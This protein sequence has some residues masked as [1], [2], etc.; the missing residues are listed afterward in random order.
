MREASIS[1]NESASA[2]TIKTRKVQIII[3]QSNH[4][5]YASIEVNVMPSSAPV[6]HTFRF[7]EPQNS[8]V[9]LKIPPFLQLNYPGLQ[10]CISRPTALVDINKE[11]STISVETKID[12]APQ[13]SEMTLYLFGD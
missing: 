7:Y 8:H 12:D 2:E 13:I 5:P 1:T 3:V 9:T 10:A 4:D 11:N 6:D